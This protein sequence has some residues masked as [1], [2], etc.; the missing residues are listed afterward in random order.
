MSKTK[1]ARPTFGRSPPL[2][3]FSEMSAAEK[4]REARNAIERLRHPH[5]THSQAIYPAIARWEAT[6]RGLGVEP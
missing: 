2:K 3:P 4:I 5:N 6:L 1:R